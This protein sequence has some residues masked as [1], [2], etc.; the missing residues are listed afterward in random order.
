MITSRMTRYYVLSKTRP[1]RNLK[2]LLK[3]K[4]YNLRS[5]EKKQMMLYFEDK[6]SKVFNKILDEVAQI[7]NIK[8]NIRKTRK[9]P[10][11]FMRMAFVHIATIEFKKRLDFCGAFRNHSSFFA[12]VTKR[13]HATILHWQ[14]NF[15]A[16]S[17]Y[18]DFQEVNKVVI[19]RFNQLIK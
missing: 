3:V 2:E 1:N 5:I 6:Y 4:F 10:I 15:E 14:R 19:E 17:I 18:Q 8:E 9:Q 16:F 12:R 11:I 13:D 7:Y